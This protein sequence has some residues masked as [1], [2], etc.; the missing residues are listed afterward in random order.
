MEILSSNKFI[1]GVEM[2]KKYPETFYVPEMKYIE[3]LRPGC[4]VK[5]GYNHERFWVILTDVNKPFYTGEV[6]NYLMDSQPFNCSD[7]IT[8]KAE[9]IIDIDTDH[10]G[11]EISLPN[12]H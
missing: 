3:L 12:A 4:I 1:N 11:E 7:L 9:N 5:V 6:N 8:F 2:N 10:V